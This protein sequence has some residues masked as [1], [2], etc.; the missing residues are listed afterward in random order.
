MFFSGK[1]ITCG[2]SNCN[3]NCNQFSCKNATSKMVKAHILNELSNQLVL[4]RKLQL[5]LIVANVRFTENVLAHGKTPTNKDKNPEIFRVLLSLLQGF[6]A[7][8]L[9]LSHLRVNA[10]P[11]AHRRGKCRL[12]VEKGGCRSKSSSFCR[13]K[14]R[15]MRMTEHGRATRESGLDAALYTQHPIQ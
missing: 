4:L 3:C 5:S 2:K 7:I 6:F 13:W 14:K 8:L 10:A 9:R 11:C 15:K 12:R 1:K